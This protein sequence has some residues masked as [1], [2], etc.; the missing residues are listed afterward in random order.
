MKQTDHWLPFDYGLE[1]EEHR[2]PSEEYLFYRAVYTGDV[3]AVQKNCDENRFIDSNG[4]GML[5]RNPLINLKY[6]LVITTA[7]ITRLCAEHGMEREQAFRLSDHYIQK[8]DDLHSVEEVHRLHD[9][10][11]MDFTR[12]MQRLKRRDDNSRRV[13]ECKEYIYSHLHERITLDSLAEE[14][15]LS[16]SYLSRLFKK[17]TGKSVS[18]YVLKQKI[19]AAKSM[20]SFSDLPMVEIADQLAFSSQSHF[21]QRFRAQV[22]TTPKRYREEHYQI[23][24]DGEL[25]KK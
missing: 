6:H 22:G 3:D 2:I 12:K 18:D 15:G 1:A 10:L 14:F 11:V 21:I 13:H 23:P 7:L 19:N 25:A 5:S 4:V 24:W 8:L 17:E 20:L 9:E 16:P